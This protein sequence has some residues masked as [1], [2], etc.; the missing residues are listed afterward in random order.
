MRWRTLLLSRL[1][2]IAN[3]IW[4]SR[5]NIVQGRSWI[6]VNRT[7]S[8]E[9]SLLTNAISM[10]C[11]KFAIALRYDTWMICY[12]LA[13]E[14]AIYIEV[15]LRTSLRSNE[16]YSWIWLHCA[17]LLLFIRRPWTWM[18]KMIAVPNWMTVERVRTSRNDKS[19]NK[20]KQRHFWVSKIDYLDWIHRGA[21]NGSN[22]LLWLISQ[23][24]ETGY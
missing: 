14:L 3:Q 8:T 7:S 15:S 19:K 13:S 12:E 11:K 5:S 1:V 6:R 2:W 24:S 20:F 21:I 9:N 22:W 10:F 23:S 17:F 16:V 18:A 4:L